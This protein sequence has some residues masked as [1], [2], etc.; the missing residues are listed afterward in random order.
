MKLAIV[1]K[2]G[3]GKTTL[4]AALARRLAALARPVVAV[5]AD[6]DGNLAAALGVPAEACLSPLPKCES[7]VL[8]RTGARDEGAGLMFK[9]NPRVDDLPQRFAVDAGGVRLLVLGTVELGGKGCMCPEGAV[10][11]ALMQHLLLWVPDRRDLGHGGR[12]GA[13]GPGVGPRRGRHDYRGRA[14]NAERANG[15]AD[16]ETG[17]RHRHPPHA[18]R[19]EQD[20]PARMSGDPPSGHWAGSRCSA[21]FPTRPTGFRR[22]GGAAVG[23]AGPRLRRGGRLHRRSDR[24]TGV[25]ETTVNNEEIVM[26]QG[27]RRSADPA[28]QEMMDFALRAGVK[29]VW[30]RLRAQEP[31]C[32]FGKMGI[33][34]RNCFMG[35]CRIDPFGEGAQEGIC[36]ATADVIVARNLL[37]QRLPR[38]GGPLRSRA[39]NR[40]CP[41]AGGGGEVGGLQDPR[42]RQ[43]ARAWPTSTAIAVRRPQRRRRGQG[44]GPTAPG[45]VRQA[46]GDPVEPAAGPRAAAEELGGGGRSC[47]A[48]STARSSPACT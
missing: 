25:G 28:A 44:A 4:A 40:A 46:G 31:Q 22:F 41:A 35:P 1:G 47:R 45:G 37:R 30:D 48:A 11:K 13:H 39:G 27:N 9:F 7:L 10:L 38:D 23:V 17:R 36:G 15:P 16:P 33:C 6:P 19:G 32:G 24:P 5:D 8:E 34:C 12:A 42:P 26:G 29:T 43:A 2:G 21:P 18:G 14:G 20:P 3:V